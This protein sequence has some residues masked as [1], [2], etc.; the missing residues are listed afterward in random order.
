MREADVLACGSDGRAWVSAVGVGEW[1]WVWAGGSGCG[2]VHAPDQIWS[3]YRLRR[4]AWRERKSRLFF[5]RSHM[6]CTRSAT[7]DDA[8]ETAQTVLEKGVVH[9]Q[10]R[11]ETVG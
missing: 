11:W 7:N 9:D 1:E 5:L 8:V 10:R 6:N 3:K 2:W 4:S